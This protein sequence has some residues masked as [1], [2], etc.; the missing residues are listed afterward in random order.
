MLKLSPK[1]YMSLFHKFHI[2]LDMVDSIVEV[3]VANLGIALNIDPCTP[4][5]WKGNLSSF[6]DGFDDHF[7]NSHI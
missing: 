2:Y 5:P 4:P 1:G 6:I 7:H 3:H